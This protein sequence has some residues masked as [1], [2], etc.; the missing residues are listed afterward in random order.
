MTGGLLNIALL[1]DEQER[2]IDKYLECGEMLIL[3]DN[4][5]KAECVVTIDADGIYELKNVAVVGCKQNPERI[6]RYENHKGNTTAY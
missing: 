5:V 1:A 4:G 2:M 6:K 3:Y